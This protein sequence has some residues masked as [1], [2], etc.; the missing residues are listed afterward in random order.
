MAFEKKVTI[1]N[2]TG[3]H[4]RPASQFVKKADKFKS[5]IEIV[6]G[7]KEVNAKSIMGVMSLGISQGTEII[8]K[9]EGEDEEEAINKLESFIKTEMEE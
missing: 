8:L 9:A 6:F 7:E 4:A 3:L 2:E 1:T 5:K